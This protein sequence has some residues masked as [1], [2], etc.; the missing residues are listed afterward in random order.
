MT[1]LRPDVERKICESLGFH[2]IRR[3]S[4]AGQS[5]SLSRTGRNTRNK[6][7]SAVREFS[8]RRFAVESLGELFETPQ[9]KNERLIRWVDW[10][11]CNEKTMWW[12]EAE[13]H[14]KTF[15]E[16]EM[17]DA[18][19]A[20][21]ARR[22]LEHE[23]V[24]DACLLEQILDAVLVEVCSVF[25]ELVLGSPGL[26]IRAYGADAATERDICTTIDPLKFER[27]WGDRGLVEARNLGCAFTAWAPTWYEVLR[28]LLCMVRGENYCELRLCGD[29]ENRCDRDRPSSPETEWESE[30]ETAGSGTG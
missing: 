18:S 4:L 12:F 1:D 14:L 30:S 7:L 21:I 22:G 16:L 10:R 24:C 25:Y 11:W 3:L 2:D 8:G 6:I 9:I 29:T 5:F 28:T 19:I 27:W 13:L 15:C 23:L 17:P 20:S 26:Q